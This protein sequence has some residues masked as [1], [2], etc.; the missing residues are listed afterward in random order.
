MIRRS[1]LVCVGA[2]ALRAQ[3]GSSVIPFPAPATSHAACGFPALR[4]PARFASR[5]MGPIAPET[6]SAMTADTEHGNHSQ[7]L[8]HLFQP[9]PRRYR[10]RQDRSAFALTYS[11]RLR[12]CRLMGAFIITPLPLML[13]KSSR[14]AGSL[15]ST[16][17]TPLPRYYGPS[18]HR[19]AFGRL[20]GSSGYTTYL[21]PPISRWGEDGFSSCSARPCHRATPTTPP[22]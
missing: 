7:R 6:L 9:K 17:V 11:L 4:A 8:L 2:F 12:S 19:L 15:C 1:P 14:A 21:A 10:E 16:G 13:T 20:P 5:V 22:E 3:V 18:R